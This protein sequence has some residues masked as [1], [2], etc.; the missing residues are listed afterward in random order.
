[1]NLESHEYA[2]AFSDE[3]LII[4]KDDALASLI[5]GGFNE[6]S[7][8]IKNYSIYL[9]DKRAVYLNV[10]EA[11]G[12][13]SRFLREI[14]LLDDLFIDPITKSLLIEMKE[15]IVFKAL[16][17]RACQLLLIDKHP[18]P[19]D[20]KF[21]RIKGYERLAG[22]VYNELVR[23]V[24]DHGAKS[25]KN[26]S[27]IE[28]HPYAVWRRITQDPSI[29]MCSDINPIEDL[30]STEAVTYAGDGGRTTQSMSK[31][32]R[33]YDPS[34]MG[35]ISEATVDSSDVAVNIFMS[36]DPQFN[37]LRG[38]TKGYEIGK[39]GVTA[40]LSTSA[41]L[42]PGSDHDDPKRVSFVSIQNGHSVACD[43][44]TQPTVR[45]GYEQVIGHRTSDLFASTAKQDCKVISRTDTGIIIENADGTRKGIELGRRFGAA[46]GLIIPHDIVCTLKEGDKLKAGDIIS[47]NQGFFERDF[48][49]P[50]NIILKTGFNVKT[51]LYESNQTIEDSSSISSDL[52]TKLSTKTTKVKTIVVSFDQSIRNLVKV[53]TEVDPDTTLC[54]VE[55]SVTTNSNLFD[56]DSLNTLRLLSS[57]APAA[58]VKGTIDK[59][60]VF[61]NGELEDMSDSLRALATASDREL[62][63][64]YKSHGKVGFTGS[65][66]ED[67]RVEGD[68]LTLDTCAIKIYMT[69][70]VAAGVGDKGVFCNQMK[71]VFGEV[72]TDEMLTETGEKIDAVFGYVSI[73]ARI[74]L[75]PE[76]IGTTN[77]LLDVVTKEAVKIYKGIK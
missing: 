39:T 45:T 53:G 27:P 48:L 64:K 72:M 62:S 49:N 15:P 77:T 70:D 10:L 30:K 46:A 26:N 73:A 54:F 1:M 61:Y 60:E 75:S 37:S 65:V 36:A 34:D 71:T 42:A 14:T 21:M 33:I 51:A 58:K 23:S 55:D 43:G 22:A 63:K 17:V 19:L 68:P 67:F 57:Q 74:V 5:I 11:S 25:G 47:Y 56:E 69:G 52:A 6:Y 2:I 9:F 50:S 41:L 35:I 29:N 4:S 8:A 59:I 12:V 31:S 7:R 24:R 40:L 18:N 76:L 44:Y 13:G 20:M 16:L 32:N 3:T 38:T 66:S 28:L